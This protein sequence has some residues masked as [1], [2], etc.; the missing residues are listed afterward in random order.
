[1]FAETWSRCTLLLKQSCYTKK[2]LLLVTSLSI[3]HYHFHSPGLLPPPPLPPTSFPLA[4]SPTFSLPSPPPPHPFPL[5]LLLTPS[6]PPPNPPL[7]LQPFHYLPP[8]S[9]LLTH[10]PNSPLSFQ[11]LPSPPS[12]PPSPPHP[13]LSL[14]FKTHKTML[15]NRSRT[16]TDTIVRRPIWSKSS[17]LR[18]PPHLPQQRQH[19]KIPP[20]TRKATANTK[21][22]VVTA[23]IPLNSFTTCSGGGVV[24]VCV[25][26]GRGEVCVSKFAMVSCCHP[27]VTHFFFKIIIIKTFIFNAFFLFCL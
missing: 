7:S 11:P 12:S 14:P 15:V 8:S 25:H 6:P 20:A 2:A 3:L 17:C 22:R 27:D 10:P 1:M 21:P 9:S 24:C 13:I 23:T 26:G 19:Q 16:M 18:S 4:I 5:L